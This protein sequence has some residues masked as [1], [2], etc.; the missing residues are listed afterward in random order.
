MEIGS[1]KGKS[2]ICLAA[3]AKE[4]KN[5]RVAAIDPHCASYVH[6]PGQ[7]TEQEL[8]RNLYL[9]GLD[10]KVDVIVATS[11]EA[12]AR[13]NHPVSL[14]WIDGDHR[15]ESVKLD[16]MLWSP[17]LVEGGIVAFHDTFVWPGPERVVSEFLVRATSWCD[18]R[19]VGTVTYA[20]KSAKLGCRQLARKCLQAALRSFHGVRLRGGMPKR[21]YFLMKELKKRQGL[22]VLVFSPFLS[23][24]RLLG[25]RKV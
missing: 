7:T 4:G 20:T 19:Y 23:L 16:F 11:E 14:L 17:H 15:Y 18:L 21:F 9:A 22:D 2:T 10:E 24:R 6:A 12:C 3:G 1:W 13:W 8:R 25:L 5:V